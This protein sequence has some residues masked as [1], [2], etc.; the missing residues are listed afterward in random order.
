[1]ILH[2]KKAY[3]E[4]DNRERERERERAEIVNFWVPLFSL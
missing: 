2:I 4:R 3:R 1:M